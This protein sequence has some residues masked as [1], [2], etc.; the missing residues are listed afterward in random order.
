MSTVDRVQA[1]VMSD[2][3]RGALAPGT[4]L[5]QD[6]LAG[7]LGVSKIPVREA[8]QRLAAIGLIR[9]ET[10]RGAMVPELTAADAEENYALRRAV[11]PRLLLQ[12]VPR[13]S[14]VDFAEA[15]MALGGDGGVAARNWAFHGALY[16]A[17]GWQR[18]VAMT[19]ILYASVAP[20]VALYTEDLGGGQHS[21]DEHMALLEA[22]R[23]GDTARAIDL[24]D[25]HLASA[26]TT[27]IDF[28]SPAETRDKDPQ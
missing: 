22:C 11:E 21:E 27:L 23:R 14:I 10:N 19:E 18:G 6:E 24:L 4:F 16:R 5:R 25:H 13:M 9:F 17:S 15:E 26:A 7:R 12:A 2:L 8:L 28:L 3:L 20:Y 1:A